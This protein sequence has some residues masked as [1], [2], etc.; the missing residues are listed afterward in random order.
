MSSCAATTLA[1]AAAAFS[2]MK[3]VLS[4]AQRVMATL[5]LSAL[6]ASN[7]AC[8]LCSV[9]DLALHS[10]SVLDTSFCQIWSMV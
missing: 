3:R 8:D 4:M 5:Y 1:A 2:S 7:L 6:G 9:Y 10:G